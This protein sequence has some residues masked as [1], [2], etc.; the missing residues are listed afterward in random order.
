MNS[1]LL[2]GAHFTAAR[3]VYDNFAELASREREGVDWAIELCRAPGSDLAHIAIHGGGIEV[4][5]TE[6]ARAAAG[7]TDNYYSFRGKKSAGNGTL[8][9]T[10]SHFDEPE[11]VD[12]QRDMVR[13]VS[14]HG[15]SNRVMVTE[16]GGLDE[17]FKHWVTVSLKHAG[18]AVA[19]A[20]PERAGESPR[21][22]CNRN[23]SGR[24]VQLELSTAQR[25][26]F[27]KDGDM[28][29]LNRS[30]TTGEFDRYIAAIQAAYRRL[31]A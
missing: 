2:N 21:N 10:A 31:R 22:I 26:V 23:L 28:S 4:G 13:T 18:F 29:A 7:R 25:A 14:W 9:I 19:P 24:G 3:D 11:C 5:T 17:E 8:H 16:V 30:K 1:T 20:S 27:F 6:A 12:L 15:F